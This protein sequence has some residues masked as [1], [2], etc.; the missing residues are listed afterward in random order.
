MPAFPEPSESNG[1]LQE[2]ARLLRSSLRSLTGMDL[3]DPTLD[4]AAAAHALFHAPF[5]VVS[6]D[7]AED[8]VFNY[9]NLTALGL[10][11]MTWAEFTALP[12]RFSAE[13]P[14]REERARLLAEVTMSGCIRNYAGVRI[15]RTGRRFRISE[16]TVWN[17]TDPSGARAGQAAMF[18]HWEPA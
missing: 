5:A 13:A 9:A 4:D 12:S 11:E 10:F 17:L 15:S 3:T 6:H 2:H 8:P 14:N 18:A 7:T 16:A 1:H